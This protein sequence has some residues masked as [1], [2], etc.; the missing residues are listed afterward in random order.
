M[1][2]FRK[3][4]TGKMRVAPRVGLLSDCLFSSEIQISNR[5]R[6]ERRPPEHIDGDYGAVGRRCRRDDAAAESLESPGP[7]R[8]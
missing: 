8:D 3:K 1:V 2:R 7:D 5:H 6:R 4:G